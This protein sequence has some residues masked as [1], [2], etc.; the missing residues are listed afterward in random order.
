MSNFYRNWIENYGLIQFKVHSLDN[1]VLA[2][3]H[4]PFFWVRFRYLEKERIEI[5]LTTI[6]KKKIIMKNRGGLRSVDKYHNY[7]ASL[8]AV[9]GQSFCRT[10]IACKN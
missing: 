3:R 2:I 10:I 8:I 6:L 7:K 5:K 4:Y 9:K 1:F